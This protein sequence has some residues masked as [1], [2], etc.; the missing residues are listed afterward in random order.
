MSS[1]C[2]SAVKWRASSARCC[3]AVMGGTPS[4]TGRFYRSDQ[5]SRRAKGEM[6]LTGLVLEEREEGSSAV[7]RDHAPVDIV[8]DGCPGGVPAA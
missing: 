4:A 6:G 3:C 2:S 5:K 8:D 1:E 7:L